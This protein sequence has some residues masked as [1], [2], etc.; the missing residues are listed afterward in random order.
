MFPS[1]SIL[2][3]T[4]G[5]P[6]Q[7]ER[8]LQSL[9]KMTSDLSHLEIVLYVDDDDPASH[10]IQCDDLSLIKIIGP[11]L[12]MGGLNTACLER[13]TGDIIVPL[14]D[15]MVLRTSGWDRRVVEI[16]EGFPDRIY[17][18]YPND[19][20]SRE[21][22]C[23][24]P[25]LSR[26]TCEVLT[27]PFPK[28]YQGG[29]IDYHLMDVFK[30]LQVLGENRIVYLDDVVIEHLHYQYGKSEADAT[31]EQRGPLNVGDEVFVGL[32]QYRQD[33]SRRLLAYIQDNPLPAQRPMQ[34]DAPLPDSNSFAIADYAGKFLFDAAL[35]L[36]WR[37][38]CFEVLSRRYFLKKY[39]YPQPTWQY[40]L[41]KM[42]APILKW[43]FQL[44]QKFKK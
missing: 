13:S 1:I 35:P 44:I 43:P 2:L 29:F 7:A 17:L 18:A 38:Y 37:T 24:T 36:S 12:P 6:E 33:S 8:F 41:L 30:R 10:A 32:R 16:H 21:L 9:V 15:D 19:L 27:H 28:L 25:I 31:Y 11:R 20:Y 14:N 23:S 42:L 40:K 22:L 3:P 34:S 39:K 4:R 26:T 5:R